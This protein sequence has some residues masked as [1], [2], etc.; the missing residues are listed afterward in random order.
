LA[1]T[2]LVIDAVAQIRQGLG[3]LRLVRN[4]V[5][6]TLPSAGLVQ[7]AVKLSP[8]VVGRQAVATAVLNSSS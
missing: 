2:E 3:P 7:P 6:A 4:V 8:T 1:G 5:P